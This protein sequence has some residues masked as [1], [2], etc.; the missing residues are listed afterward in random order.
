MKISK[1][2]RLAIS[3]PVFLALLLLHPG[4]IVELLAYIVL[5]LFLS[6][7]MLRNTIIKIKAKNII[8][9]SFLMLIACL[10]AFILGEYQEAIEVIFLFSLGELLEERAVQ[11]SRRSITQLMDICPEIAHVIGENGINDSN[12]QDIN[13]G[14]R[15]LIKRG[16]K[17]PLDGIILK[18]NA[19]LDMKALNGEALPKSLGIGDEV[20][21]GAILIGDTI[22][23][24]VTRSYENSTASKILDLVENAIEKKANT[25][26]AISRFARLYTPSV[27]A[28]A[29]LLVI[30]PSVFFGGE[31]ALWFK[32]ALIFLVVSCPC[33]L[34]LSIPM[35]FV[36][37]IAGASKKGILFKGGSAIEAFSRVKSFVFDKT[38]TLSQGKLFVKEIHTKNISE[39]ELMSLCL[40]IESK[41]S[42]PIAREICEK[43]AGTAPI[44][45]LKDT[46][47]I[48]GLGMTAELEGKNLAIGGKKLMQSLN[49]SNF[50]EDSSSNV[51]IALGNEH[52]G[53]LLIED[54]IKP[55][56]KDALNE[57]RSLSVDDFYILSGD[58]R[59]AT[60]ELANAL[61]IK[62][63][64]GELL[65][66]DKLCELEKIISGSRLNEKTCFVGD[67]I[68]DAPCIVRA[69]IGVAMGMSGSDSAIEAA[70]IVLME[71]KLK[72]LS[73]ALRLSRKTMRTVKENIIFALSVKLVI[74]VLAAL[75][76]SSMH[77]A[78]FGDVGVALITILNA[79]KLLRK[80]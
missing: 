17:I 59:N 8:N 55:D 26:R 49:I 12:P 38:G 48:P 7:E 29:L 70:D 54:E 46:R 66:Q 15:L 71:D 16:E 43:F 68:N 53:S 19:I 24:E 18:G 74:M 21:S 37:G 58:S 39:S 77:M 62:K 36:A 69:D 14:E 13:I 1:K 9:E 23:I 10:G 20:L 6:E 60:N 64:S 4:G 33:A 80:K 47:E 42:H 75:G 45:E 56:A 32:R 25:E 44:K 76:L 72:S 31:L 67:G 28:A 61:G 27:V 30:I 57:L 52:I 2:I 73:E 40:S 51:H 41:S 63:S 11:K 35:S 34:V 78:V 65:P 79:T 5:F 22:E 50:D 3:A